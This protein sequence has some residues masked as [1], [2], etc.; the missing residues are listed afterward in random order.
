M[1]VIVGICVA[2]FTWSQWR[3]G[4]LIDER[5]NLKIAVETQAKNIKQ[6]KKD[7]EEIKII[8]SDLSKTIQDSNRAEQELLSKL[9]NIGE[10]AKKAPEEVQIKINKSMLLRLRCFELATGSKPEKEEA[11]SL[12]PHLL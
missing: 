6:L 4:S 8:N 1:A 2:Y 3:I 7:A 10:I 9:E 11:N 5:S 12:C